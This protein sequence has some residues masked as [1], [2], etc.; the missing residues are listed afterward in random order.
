[1]GLDAVVYRNKKHLHLGEDEKSAQLIPERGEVYFEN[2]EL[3]RKHREQLIAA[4][5][6]LGNIT[7]IAEL[8]DE[9]SRLTVPASILREKVLYSGSHSGDFIPFDELS[10]LLDEIHL[11]RRT[12]KAS[13]ELQS[14]LDSIE[15][16]IRAATNETNPIVF[17]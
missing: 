3:S 12:G 4:G 5:A 15:E 7:E 14:F 2:D 1:V 10:V 11:V 6:R 9:L 16:L 13:R 8:R 17:V